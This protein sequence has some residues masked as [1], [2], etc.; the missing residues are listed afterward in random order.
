MP[1]RVRP[2]TPRDRAAIRALH[3]AAFARDGEADL[4]ERLRERAEGYLGLVAEDA[5]GVVGHVAFSPVEVDGASGVVGLA[6]VGVLPGRQG[7]G[8]GSQ[9][10][11]AGLEA[12]REAGARAAV[13]LG[14]PS[15]YPR[16]GF[17]PAGGFGVSTVYDA[18]PDAFMAL[19]LVPGALEG[20][21]GVA[22]Y[23]PA[24]VG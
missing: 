17:T 8:I 14:R 22:R 1:V 2:E 16:F 5:S 15:Y 21:S 20:A 24:F 7:E 9:L 12:S 4:V 3:A 19:E 18:P 23:H 10:I 13:V 11:R 6:P